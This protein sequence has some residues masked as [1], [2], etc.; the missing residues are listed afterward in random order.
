MLLPDKM[1]YQNVYPTHLPEDCPAF[2]RPSKKE[3]EEI[4]VL[5]E[6]MEDTWDMYFTYMTV[7]YATDQGNCDG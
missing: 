5:K 1:S 3:M 6:R 2:K 7:Y 4:R